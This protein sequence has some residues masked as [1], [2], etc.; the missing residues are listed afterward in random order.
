MPTL[1]VGV[2]RGDGIGPEVIGQGINVLSAIQDVSDLKFEVR[3]L[4]GGGD[5]FLQTGKPM[6]YETIDECAKCHII[7]KGPTGAPRVGTTIP[8]GTM[9]RG[10]IL[11][12]RQE[13]DLY[14]NL[15]PAKPIYMPV[16][17]KAT[18]LKR[19]TINGVDI[20]FV[21]ENSEGLY[22]LLSKKEKELLEEVRKA[23][24]SAAV[25][26]MKYTENGVNRIIR[27]AFDLAKVKG[28]QK[29]ASLDKANVIEASAY[30][31]AVFKKISE[32]YPDAKTDSLYIDNACYQS[33]MD[34]L[35]AFGNG[36]AVTE[37]VFGDIV[38]DVACGAISGSLG[39]CGSANV[40]PERLYMFEPRQME[41]YSANPSGA[42]MAE[43]VHG[44]YP[45]VAGQ[46]RANPIGA[47]KSVE[48]ALDALGCTEEAEM[49]SQAIV[50]A[51]KDGWR[52][53]DIAAGTKPCS[54]EQMGNAIAANIRSR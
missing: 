15:R 26:L 48:L 9:E 42:V 33:V 47:I 11:P 50:N 44:T 28:R 21:R 2:I 13:R 4:P 23:G 36:V 17:A 45:Q 6:P 8:E 3:Y 38:T 40:N 39:L 43:A 31:K 29:V 52:T 20:L 7:Y 16:S 53:E 32:E 22:A 34:P 5:Y 37:N 41:M 18:G 19:K 10:L 51:L 54:T 25:G 14:A 30:W 24:G 12:I 46:N 27:L 35:R 1:T 49:I